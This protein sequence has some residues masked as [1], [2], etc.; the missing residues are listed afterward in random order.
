MLCG[1]EIDHQANLH[2]PQIE[3][4]DIPVVCLR[5]P[6]FGVSFLFDGR[7]AWMTRQL[8]RQLKAKQARVS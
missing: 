1:P 8:A 5:G 4:S 7:P 3:G 2:D 6:I